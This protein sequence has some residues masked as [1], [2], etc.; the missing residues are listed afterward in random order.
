MKELIKQLANMKYANLYN[1][2]S[3]V[4][5]SINIDQTINNLA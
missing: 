1:L 2:I 3:H 4:Y 5:I